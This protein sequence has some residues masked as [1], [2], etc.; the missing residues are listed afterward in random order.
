MDVVPLK[1]FAE[2]E[3]RFQRG[4]YGELGSYAS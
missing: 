4:A 3:L 1:G 2:S